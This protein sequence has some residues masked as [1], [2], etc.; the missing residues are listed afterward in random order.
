[1]AVLC[2]VALGLLL[3]VHGAATAAE[4]PGVQRVAEFDPPATPEDPNDK[5]PAALL[6]A[7]SLA[8][9]Q[10]TFSV[11]CTTCHGQT[12]GGGLGPNLTDQETVHGGRFADMLNVIMNGVE[13]KG[14]PRWIGLIGA[15]RVAQVAAYVYTLKGTRPPS[16]SNIRFSVILLAPGARLLR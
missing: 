10:R 1:L 8:E 12:G 9:G 5:P 16:K 11:H 6:T 4:A 13:L 7:E 3:A 14:M 15:E 2:G